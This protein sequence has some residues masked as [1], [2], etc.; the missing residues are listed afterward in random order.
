MLISAY[1]MLDHRT[2][3]ESN[4]DTGDIVIKR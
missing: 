1:T 2:G 3:Y 4:T